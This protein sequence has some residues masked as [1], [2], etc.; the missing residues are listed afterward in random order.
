MARVAPQGR[1]STVRQMTDPDKVGVRPVLPGGK[2]YPKVYNVDLSNQV[3][4]MRVNVLM[5]FQRT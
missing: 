3:G 4:L 2:S 5:L 1:T